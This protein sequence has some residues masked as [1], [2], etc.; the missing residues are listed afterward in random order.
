M[1]KNYIPS[2]HKIES[3]YR[4][5]FDDGYGNGYYFYCDK[6]GNPNFDNDAQRKN[7]EHCMKHPKS[8]VRFNKI[9]KETYSYVE[10]AQAECECGAKFSLVSG[11]MGACQCPECGKW[12]NLFGQELQAPQ[13]W[14]K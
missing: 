5:V 13:Y 11:Y 3:K 12:Y 6:D 8:F 4:L 10:P 14:D 7:Y 1:L 9:V 2:E